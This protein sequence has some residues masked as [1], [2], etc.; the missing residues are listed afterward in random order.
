MEIAVNF[1]SPIVAL[2]TAPLLFGVINKTKAFFAGRRGAPLLQAYY[3]LFKLMRKDRV[4]SE[5][6]STI[7]KVSPAIIFAST[8]AAT[9]FIPFISLHSALSF[10]GDFVL[11]FYLLGLARFFLILYALDTGSSFEGMGASREAFLSALAEPVVFIVMLTLLRLE[12][13]TSIQ[14]AFA[15]NGDTNWVIISLSVIP[16]FIVLLAE[17]ARIPFDDPNTHL[18]LTMI[19][20]VMIL[21]SSGPDLGVFEYAASIKFWLFSLIIAKMLFPFP[22]IGIVGEIIITAILMVAVSITVGVVESIMARC[23]FA[24]MPQL[25]YSAA[26]IAMIAFFLSISNIAATMVSAK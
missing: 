11:L 17:N 16:M 4:I 8:L 10:T 1:I 6:T 3:D 21:D 24:K 15:A 23:R 22:H 25:M 2:I 5:T 26:V 9:L 18:E 12:S 20:E 13:T 7:S 19:H 14:S